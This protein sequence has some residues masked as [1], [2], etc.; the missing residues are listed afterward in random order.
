MNDKNSIFSALIPIF[1][2]GPFTGHL[3]NIIWNEPVQD[4]VIR[5]KL[6]KLMN[7]LGMT[8]SM[9]SLSQSEGFAT[10]SWEQLS[11]RAIAHNRL[12]D[13]FV[14]RCLTQADVDESF[15]TKLE[16][17]LN[18]ESSQHQEPVLKF[19]YLTWGA[20]AFLT[21]VALYLGFGTAEQSQNQERN[22]LLFILLSTFMSNIVAPLF[23]RAVMSN[24]LEFGMRPILVWLNRLKPI[25]PNLKG[26][27]GVPGMQRDNRT[28]NNTTLSLQ[29]HLELLQSLAQKQSSDAQDSQS[30][31]CSLLLRNGQ[32]ILEDILKEASKAGWKLQEDLNA[33]D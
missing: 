20:A 19:P 30:K 16:A 29:S 2:L 26:V 15:V 31:A 22:K 5:P 3:S 17:E 8:H 6:A 11:Y 9:P 18:F 24:V 27:L 13:E 12:C 32:E 7:R 21:G 28:F 4:G 10:H 14:K 25:L 23:H 33:S 1:F